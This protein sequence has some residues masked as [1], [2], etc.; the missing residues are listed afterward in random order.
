[1]RAIWVILIKLFKWVIEIGMVTNFRWH[2]ELRVVLP[3]DLGGLNHIFLI[4]NGAS[5][6]SCAKMPNWFLLTQLKWFN[7]NQLLQLKV[8][9]PTLIFKCSLS[10]KF[11]I[12]FLQFGFQFLLRYLNSFVKLH[13][14][15]LKW[16]FYLRV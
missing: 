7:R 4:I 1:M 5:C 13:I 2:C 12:L 15:S 14:N 3:T 9:N 10:I 11:D 8:F 16:L 6:S